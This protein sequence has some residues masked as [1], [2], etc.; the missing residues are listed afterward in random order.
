MGL[1]GG[2]VN[3]YLILLQSLV[4][5]GGVISGT[6]IGIGTTFLFLPLLDFSGGLPPYLV[7]IAWTDIIAVYVV[8]AAVLLAVTFLTTLFI[9]RESL[10][11]IVKL[12]DA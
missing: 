5:G 8:F 3:R 6:V 10:S 12:G 1:G 11:T 4:A 9:G 7:R 2:A